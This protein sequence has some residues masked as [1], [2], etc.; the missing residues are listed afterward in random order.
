MILPCKSLH[1]RWGPASQSPG[2]RNEQE[3]VGKAVGAGEEFVRRQLWE[4]SDS[5]RTKK[6]GGPQNGDIRKRKHLRKLRAEPAREGLAGAWGRQRA[7]GCETARGARRNEA[8]ETRL[9]N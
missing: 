9:G 3:Q 5:G 4:E 8:E 6:E 7:G 1:E 2:W